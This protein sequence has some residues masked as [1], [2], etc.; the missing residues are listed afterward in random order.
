MPIPFS[1]S[2]RSL[3]ADT[4]RRSIGGIVFASGLLAL[5]ALWFFF[6]QVSV[7]EVTG[8]ARLE[9]DSRVYPVEAAVSGKIVSH[10]LVLGKEVVQG[11]VLVELDARSLELELAERRKSLG[12]LA[13]QRDFLGR[14]SGSKQRAAGEQRVSARAGFDEIRAQHA[15]AEAAARFAEGQADRLARLYEAGLVARASLEEAETE[16]ERRRSVAE[17]LRMAVSRLQAEKRQE[18]SDIRAELDRLE[19]DIAR[20]GAEVE[21]TIEAIERLDYEVD[22]RRVR[23]PRSGWLGEVADVQPGAVVR[24]GEKLGTIIPGGEVKIVAYF[25]PAEALGR[26]R[27]GQLAR[28]RLEGF[29]W[30]QYG[31][32]SASVASVAREPRQQTVRVELDVTRGATSPELLQHGLPGSVEVE[33]ERVSPASLVLRA[34]GKLL[35][36]TETASPS[37]APASS[38][39]DARHDDDPGEDLLQTL[40]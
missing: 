34:A 13:S 10:H 27:V 19:G 33:V 39:S 11:D 16:A 32:V 37:Q 1:R 15:E 25:S 24:E 23:A 20:V 5:W 40:R 35:G 18:S 30:T 14:E 4:Y 3:E 28:L 21:A 8:T 9:A 26:I 31:S 36:V 38:S 29:P 6:A 12:G 22:R 17:S 2:M 7:Y